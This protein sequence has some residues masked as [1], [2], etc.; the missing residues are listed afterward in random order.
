MLALATFAFWLAPGG[1]SWG[2]DKPP[3]DQGCCVV[4]D[5]QHSPV[6]VVFCT[7]PGACR[8]GGTP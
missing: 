1:T 3:P 8:I 5:F 6:N 2:A 4:F 7:T